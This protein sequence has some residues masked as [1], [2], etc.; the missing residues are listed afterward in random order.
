M[1]SSFHLYMKLLP[2]LKP[3]KRYVLFQIAGDKAFTAD[4]VKKAVDEALKSF[5]GDLGLAKA[6][7]SFIKER[8][9]NN[10]FIIKV[11]HD[12]VDELKSAVILIKKIKNNPVLLKSIVTSGALQK[13]ADG[14]DSKARL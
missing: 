13:A 7:P 14:V 10:H 6:S 1:S 9:K 5:L 12:W 2:S 3:K 4:E 8:Y 11:N